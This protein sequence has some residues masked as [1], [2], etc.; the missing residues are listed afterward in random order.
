[1][2]DLSCERFLRIL[3][4]GG[5]RSRSVDAVQRR[6]SFRALLNLAGS[7]EAG[8]VVAEDRIVYSARAEIPIRLYRPEHCLP[9][10]DP[11]PT[12]VF[13]HG[14]GFVAGSIETHDN[15]CRSLTHASKWQL[16][17]VGYRLAPEHPYPAPVEDGLTVLEALMAQPAGY[18]ADPGC[19]A[20][21]GD[22]VG[23]GIA[24]R[25]CQTAHE[26]IAVGVKLQ[27]LLCPAFEEQPRFAS[28]TAF[29][30]GYSIDADMIKTDFDS[31]R[32]SLASLPSPLDHRGFAEL[33]PA[34]VHVA[35][36]DPFR[37]EGFAFARSLRTAE[38]PV[39]V[40]TH[41]GMLHI[42]H[43][44]SRFIPQGQTLLQRV[45]DQLKRFAAVRSLEARPDEGRAIADN[46]A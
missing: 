34:I 38:V 13:F 6:E 27:V 10:A 12:C 28:R 22:S 40:T 20:I 1:M 33:P 8:P 46:C 15:I 21:A 9:N 37:D 5:G 18:R 4:A 19:I 24:L 2:L 35:E 36:C 11:M 17:S 23:A 14:G 43:A 25:I 39:S 7:A 45:G 16:V 42:F 32:G 30:R 41:A 29:A 26:R 44:F 31:F 3:S